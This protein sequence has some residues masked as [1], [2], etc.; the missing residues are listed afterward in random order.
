MTIHASK[1]LEYPICYFADIDH[2]FN[3]RETKERL[4]LDDK[5]GIITPNDNN[6]NVLK[7]LY[8]NNYMKE[9]IS[10]KI[11]LFYVAITRA[12]EQA[13]IVLPSKETTKLEKN[14]YGTLLL[15]RRLKYKRLSDFI[16]SCKDYL[17][18]Y[19][20]II[21][22]NKIN[23]TKDYLY[24]KEIK[25]LEYDNNIESF[26]VNT[27]KIDNNKVEDTHYSKTLDTLI[28]K[29]TLNNMKFGIQIHEILEYLDF[30]NPNLDIIDNTYIKSKINKLLNNEILKNINKADKFKYKLNDK[31]YTGVIDLML[32]Y[33]DKV[34][35]I[36][37][38]LKNTKDENYIKQL[39]GYKEYIKSKTNKKINTYLYSIID[40][41]LEEV[42]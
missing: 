28:D 33:D 24:K 37:Y 29:N 30:K 26:D 21:D 16:Y 14:E 5:Y 22:I 34:D 42:L 9:E 27:I 41:K 19:F 3:T 39:N 13:I 4:I 40:D 32:I 6:D 8:K 35:I 11:R 18:K 20:K 23:L 36:D 31:N 17:K 15:I 1:G 2:D 38:K 10:E 25:K 7:I 12:R